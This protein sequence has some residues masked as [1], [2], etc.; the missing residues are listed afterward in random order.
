MYVCICNGYREAQ[1]LQLAYRGL[2]CAEEA[3]AALGTGPNCRRCL[4]CAQQIMD[5]YHDGVAGNLVA[6]E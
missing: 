1:L 2:T 3:Y 6:A 5:D 4:D